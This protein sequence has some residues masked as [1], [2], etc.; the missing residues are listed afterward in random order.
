M[1]FAQ[2][3]SIRFHRE[4]RI[5]VMLHADYSF[6][7]SIS[8]AI[9]ISFIFHLVNLP[10][11]ISTTNRYTRLKKNCFECS[12]WRHEKRTSPPY[13][14]TTKITT[15]ATITKNKLEKKFT[16]ILLQWFSAQSARDI[17]WRDLI[18]TNK[19][20]LTKTNKQTN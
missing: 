2:K 3:K 11:N 15:T 8:I 18:Q 9:A 20:K 16:G 19:N 4:S 7:L 13:I 6:F 10:S 14:R 1:R 12:H 5:N 17:I